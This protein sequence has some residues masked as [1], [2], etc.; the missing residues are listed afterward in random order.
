MTVN[1]GVDRVLP[2]SDEP[3]ERFAELIPVLCRVNIEKCQSHAVVEGPAQR[4]LARL[5]WNQVGDDRAMPRRDDI[6]RYIGLVLNVNDLRAMFRLRPSFGSFVHPLRVE[7]FDEVVFDGWTDV[8]ESP[9][10][11]LV[12]SDNHERHAGQRHSGNIEAAAFE[13]GLIPQVRHLMVEVHIV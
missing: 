4:D 7:L 1:V 8:G 2:R 3:R 10:D 11:A 5:A 6:E 12:V 13:M 9:S